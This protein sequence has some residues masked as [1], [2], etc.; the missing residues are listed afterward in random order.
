MIRFE[1]SGIIARK[2]M[3]SNKTKRWKALSFV[4]FSLLPE[5]RKVA[6]ANA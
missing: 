2:L 5:Q 1:K 3:A 6:R 4:N